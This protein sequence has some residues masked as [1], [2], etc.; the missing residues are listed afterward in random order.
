MV[1][2]KAEYAVY[3]CNSAPKSPLWLGRKSLSFHYIKSLFFVQKTDGLY[4]LKN[5]SKSTSFFAPSSL[6]FCA[7]HQVSHQPQ[8]SRFCT[9]IKSLFQNTIC[10]SPFAYITKSLCARALHESPTYT[11]RTLLCGMRGNEAIRDVMEDRQ[12][13]YLRYVFSSS[14]CSGVIRKLSTAFWMVMRCV[15]ES[16]RCCWMYGNVASHCF[17]SAVAKNHACIMR[18]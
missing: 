1:I 7:S 14:F 12:V 4:L 11:K 9:H 15:T 8:K 13:C 17:A 5:R 16:N 2:F 6:H 3:L 18:M 10:K